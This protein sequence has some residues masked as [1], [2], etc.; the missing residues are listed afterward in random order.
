MKHSG[1]DYADEAV[2]KSYDSRH[3]TFRNYEQEANGIIAKL[4]VGPDS[5][6]LDMGC[7]T[8]AF[9]VHAARHY[10]K[11]Y[12]V[13]VSEMM[14]NCTRE[15]AT[16]AEL[17][18]IEFRHGGFLTY[19]HEGEPVDAISSVVV[20]HHL[21]DFWKLVG[22]RRLAS[23][24][25]P[26]GRF[27]LFDIVFSFDPAQYAS[28]FQQFVAVMDAQMGP[29]GGTRAQTHI[30]DEY[31]T[32]SWIMEGLLERA[33]FRIDTASNTSVEQQVIIAGRVYPEAGSFQ[34]TLHD[35]GAGAVLVT[36]MASQPWSPTGPIWAPMARHEPLKARGVLSRVEREDHVEQEEPAA[37]L[38]HRGQSPQAYEFPEVGQVVQHED[39]AGGID[40][41][42]FVFIGQEAAM[43]ELDIV[44]FRLLCLLAGAVEHHLGY[45]HG[46]HLAVVP[47]RVDGEGARPAAHVQ[48]RRVGADAEFGDD[49]VGLLLI[50]AERP[51]TRVVGLRHRL[52]GV[53]DAGVLHLVILPCRMLTLLGTHLPILSYDGRRDFAVRPAQNKKAFQV[54]GSL[55]GLSFDLVVMSR[56]S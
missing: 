16:Q 1:V 48:D 32:C 34:K 54:L 26:G 33:G 15:K 42:A 55:K 41:L 2:A 29:G 52:V 44:Q 3:G 51:V 8:G 23:M 24:L 4:G 12:A 49:P 13:D 27:F 46:V 21:P 11:V 19:E 10:R 37:R 6:I 38:E 35:P 14:L 50:V 31:S 17:H 20:L 45:V 47:R 25:K 28:C 9:A 7:G 18:N 30:R 22:L 5:A 53:V 36:D 39:A 56:L 43:T 40:R